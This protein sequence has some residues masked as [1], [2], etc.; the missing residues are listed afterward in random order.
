MLAREDDSCCFCVPKQ[1]YRKNKASCKGSRASLIAPCTT[2]GCLCCS[3]CP[4]LGNP[5]CCPAAKPSSVQH[6]RNSFSG[7]Q[8]CW[9]AIFLLSKP[10]G[11][12]QD[13]LLARYFWSG[14]NHK[15]SVIFESHLPGCILNIPHFL[16]CSQLLLCS[17]LSW[18]PLCAVSVLTGIN[19]S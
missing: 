14:R 4:L 9:F 13:S 11:V 16:W 19:G 1:P 3:P 18:Q 5:I 2:Q 6:C 17:T 10:V 8:T 15:E 12:L 7:G